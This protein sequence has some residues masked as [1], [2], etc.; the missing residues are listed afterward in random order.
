MRSPNPSLSLAAFGLNVVDE[1]APDY[2]G[3]S[4]PPLQACCND[5]ASMVL[6]GAVNGLSA[7]AF[8]STYVGVMSGVGNNIPPYRLALDCSRELVHAQIALRASFVAEEIAKGGDPLTVISISGHGAQEV[9]LAETVESLV[10]SDGL[11]PDF[12]FH[13]LL[14]LFPARARVATFLDTC[15]SGGMDRAA[16]FRFRAKFAGTVRRVDEEG[17]AIREQ[18]PKAVIKANLA[19]F[20]ACARDTTA[21]DGQHN[22][23]FTGCLLQAA[24]EAQDNKLKPSWLDVF[25]RA[26]QLCRSQFNQQPV[27]TFYGE[28]SVWEKPFMK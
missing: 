14:A 4:V 5:A 2:L 28:Q 27:A 19:I 17:R 26:V 6:L 8:V 22:G 9:Y 12:E 15:H 20:A 10:L 13:N 7:S 1:H 23:A 11:M 21:L 24:Q 18:K 3:W 25:H 16:K